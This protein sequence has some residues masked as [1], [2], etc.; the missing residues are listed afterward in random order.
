MKCLLYQ[1]PLNPQTCFYLFSMLLTACTPRS[2]FFPPPLSLSLFP[3]PTFSASLSCC[4]CSFPSR[5]CTSRTNKPCR[6]GRLII[7]K[8]KI[9][10]ACSCCEHFDNKCVNLN[11]TH[12]CI[13]NLV[14][15]N[16]STMSW[17]DEAIAVGETPFTILILCGGCWERERERNFVSQK[18]HFIFNYY[19][20][21]PCW[22]FSKPILILNLTFNICADFEILTIHKD[23]EVNWSVFVYRLFHEDF[24]LLEQ[25]LDLTFVRWLEIDLHEIVCKQIQIN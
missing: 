7:W 11:A 12:H 21:F 18:N 1:S 8:N 9:I 4:A 6:K 13:K 3:P 5:A 10:I 17:H 22:L 15:L 25:I 16:Y 14:S 20:N 19:P 24:T 2:T 23:T